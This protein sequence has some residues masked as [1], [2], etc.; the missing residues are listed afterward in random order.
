MYLGSPAA[1]CA[2]RERAADVETPDGRRSTYQG[3]VMPRGS[4]M[5]PWRRLVGFGGRPHAG[6][7]F[8][9]VGGVVADV[10]GAE[11]VVEEAA[12]VEVGTG[13]GAFVGPEEGGAAGGDGRWR[14]TARWDRGAA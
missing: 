8:P 5:R 6:V 13:T 10:E 7:V 3:K 4:Q 11:D 1:A 9:D 2:G 14:G 12:G